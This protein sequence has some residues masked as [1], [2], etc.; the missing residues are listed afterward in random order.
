VLDKLQ[1]GDYVFIQFGHNDAKKEILPACRTSY[2]LQKN[3]LRF[4]TDAREIR[5]NTDTLHAGK[6]RQ[7]DDHAASSIPHGDYRSL[8][9]SLLQ[10]RKSRSFDV[11]QSYLCNGSGRLGPDDSKRAFVWI[12]ADL[13][14]QI[15]AGR[16]DKHTL[17]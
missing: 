9:G 16:Q 8:Y 17:Q 7:Y 10:S 1:Q 2:R 4:V 6:P 11:H 5:G 13:Y 3:L 15:R 12:K 14:R